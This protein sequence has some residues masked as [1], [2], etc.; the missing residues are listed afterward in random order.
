MLYLLLLQSIYEFFFFFTFINFCLIFSWIFFSTSERWIILNSSSASLFICRT[1]SWHLFS[2]PQMLTVGNLFYWF[3]S[4]LSN[5]LM[6]C[7]PGSFLIKQGFFESSHY[8]TTHTKAFF[9]SIPVAFIR[10][11]LHFLFCI[12]TCSSFFFFFK[13]CFSASLSAVVSKTTI[14]IIHRFPCCSFPY[15]HYLTLSMNWWPL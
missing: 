13:T 1:A 11:L 9:S 5:F 3:P 7:T 14:I 10:A 15:A 2:L 4:D 8:P 12:P 6:T